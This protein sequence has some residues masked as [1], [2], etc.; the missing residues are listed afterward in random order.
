MRI[1]FSCLRSS[2][3]VGT[4]LALWARMLSAKALTA[5]VPSRAWS[6]CPRAGCDLS[7][8]G[9]AICQAYAKDLGAFRVRRA[10]R[11]VGLI[12]IEQGN[13][14]VHVLGLDGLLDATPSQ[15][16][17]RGGMQ[18]PAVLRPS[19][20]DPAAVHTVL[21]ARSIGKVSHAAIAG[22]Q[23]RWRPQG[24]VELGVRFEF[25]FADGRGQA[26]FA[27]AEFEAAL[28]AVRRR[29]LRR[30]LRFGYALG[31]DRLLAGSRGVE[32]GRAIVATSAGPQG[33]GAAVHS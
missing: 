27:P 16:H 18:E 5:R 15:H 33:V 17:D 12:A 8:L 22:P 30:L 4:R 29:P 20:D 19:Y 24:G 2:L 7:S 32:Q 23:L 26:W 1:G 14:R 9:R 10:T 3:R 28:A 21:D 11:W 25:P 6:L 31:G 13:A